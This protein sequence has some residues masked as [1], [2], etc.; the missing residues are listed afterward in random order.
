METTSNHRAVAFAKDAERILR[1]MK[2]WI[3]E[4]ASA[5][6]FSILVGEDEDLTIGQAV[7]SALE[8]LN[9][10]GIFQSQTACILPRFPTTWNPN[11]LSWD[12]AA[13]WSGGQVRGNE[14]NCQQLI[15]V[16]F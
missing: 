5:I 9:E 16:S 6:Y 15:R 2:E 12:C 3:D 14:V 8:I 4:D 10:T 13:S 1:R 11:E 7:E